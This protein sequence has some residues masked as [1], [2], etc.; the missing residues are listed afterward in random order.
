MSSLVTRPCMPVPSTCDRSTP[1]FA[2]MLR[3]SG[4]ENWRR[5]PSRRASPASASDSLARAV[6]PA[7]RRTSCFSSARAPSPRA[8][9]GVGDGEATCGAPPAGADGRAVVW[10]GAAGGPA[11]PSRAVSSRRTWVSGEASDALG[12]RRR[13]AACPV[14]AVPAPPP[15]SP[16]W[17]TTWLTGTVSPSLLRISR[18]V[19]AAGLGISASTL[20][21]EISNRG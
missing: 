4:L 20:S 19:P 12:A 7:S 13:P 2:A 6:S 15:A 10:G 16:I 9:A 1:S 5:R 17:A 14:P 3:T 11:C 18:S 21:V 8:G